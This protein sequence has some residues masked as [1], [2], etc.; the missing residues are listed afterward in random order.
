MQM[1]YLD[2]AGVTNAPTL[3]FAGNIMLLYTKLA[4]AQEKYHTTKLILLSENIR[5]QEHPSLENQFRFHTKMFKS[6]AQ[7]EYFFINNP[8]GFF[9][10]PLSLQINKCTETN[11]KYYYI[12][13]YSKVIN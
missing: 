6:D 8:V 2:E 7:I 12:L 10:Y 5:G 4:L 13:S 3:L 1:Y 11:N 9:N